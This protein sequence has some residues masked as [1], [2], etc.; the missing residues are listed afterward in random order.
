[1]VAQLQGMFGWVSIQR[2][3]DRSGVEGTPLSA[4]EV[5]F[6]LRDWLTNPRSFSLLAGMVATSG[7]RRPADL[8]RAVTH[9]FR[10]GELRATRIEL[11]PTSVE[12]PAE[13]QV[14]PIGPEAEKPTFLDVRLI[15]ATGEPV[16]N[17]R[18]RIRLAS[19][20]VRE[21]KLDRNGVVRIEEVLG[22]DFTIE[23]PDRKVA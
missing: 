17:E 22:A 21:G 16:A 19:N 4:D 7:P 3:L 8:E 20:E 2:G 14:A 11:R 13:D 9:A 18:Y 10:R 5:A 1:M 12:R 15:D 23:F 6:E